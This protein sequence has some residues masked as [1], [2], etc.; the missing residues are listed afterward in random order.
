MLFVV[1]KPSGAISTCIERAQEGDVVLLIESAVTVALRVSASIIFDDI[2][3]GVIVHVLLPDMEVRGVPLDSCDERAKL[4]DYEG[5]VRLV[6][7]HNPI[8]SCF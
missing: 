6:E 4:I 1:N 5:F 2:K 8:R 7:Q 3:S